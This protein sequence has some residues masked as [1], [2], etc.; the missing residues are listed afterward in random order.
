M[1]MSML[2]KRPLRIGCSKHFFVR[3]TTCP[4]YFIIIA[5]PRVETW[6]FQKGSFSPAVENFGVIL[7][8]V[9]PTF[10][11]YCTSSTLFFTRV[12]YSKLNS[13]NSSFGIP[14]IGL[15]CKTDQASSAWY[16]VCA[17]NPAAAATAPCLLSLILIAQKYYTLCEAVWSSDG[18]N[19]E[20]ML[21]RCCAVWC[22][23]RYWLRWAV[24]IMWLL[25]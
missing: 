10:D 25:W 16:V 4:S 17:A 2:D 1:S 18:F 6:N 23:Q 12:A 20:N 22:R 3:D 13:C 5:P 19:W 24:Y 8:N 21:E 15:L 7:C 14:K 11:I 9:H